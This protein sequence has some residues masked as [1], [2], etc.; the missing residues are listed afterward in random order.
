VRIVGRSD[1]GECVAEVVGWGVGG[2]EGLLSGADLHGSVAARGA[3]ELLYAPACLVL[4]PVVDR[5]SRKDGERSR[6][7]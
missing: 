7:M 5:Q 2:G 3:D 1:F 4:D 6:V